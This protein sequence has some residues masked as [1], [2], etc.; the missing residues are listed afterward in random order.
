MDF[1]AQRERDELLYSLVK[2]DCRLHLGLAIT[3]GACAVT[4]AVFLVFIVAQRKGPM[5][6]LYDISM[7]LGFAGAAAAWW[8][9]Y[10]NDVAALKEIGDDHTGIDTRKTYSKTTAGVISASR[11]T[12]GE[13]RQLWI[14]YGILGLVMLAFGVLMFAF[15]LFDS[16]SDAEVLVLT[17]VVM[18]V[19]GILLSSM[20]IIAFRRWMVARR[21]EKLDARLGTGANNGLD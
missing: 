9:S 3:Y 7:G 21:I 4:A 14:A 16:F 15:V 1:E 19:G 11:K 2:G 6:L 17:G 5:A 18:M 10:R 13:L 20:A 8:H 12:T